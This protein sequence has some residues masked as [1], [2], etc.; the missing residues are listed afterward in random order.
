MKSN[1]K[2]KVRP[3]PYRLH[4]KFKL[5]SADVEATSFGGEIELSTAG[6]AKKFGTKKSEIVMSLRQLAEAVEKNDYTILVP[7]EWVAAAEATEAKRAHKAS[8]KA[9]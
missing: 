6:F 5:T 9:N 4:L 1:G 8:Q 2:K 3:A 7:P